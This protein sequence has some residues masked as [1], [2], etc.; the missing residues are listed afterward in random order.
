MICLKENRFKTKKELAEH[1]SIDVS[2][3]N[4]WL[5]LY[6]ESGIKQ[7]CQATRRNKPSKLISSEIH[8]W[9]EQLLYNESNHVGGYKHLQKLIA[10]KFGKT[11]PYYG[12]YFYIR[13][14]FK[15]KFKTP[16]KS[17]GKKDQQ[18]VDAFLK[19]AEHL[20]RH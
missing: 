9:L 12:L 15:A 6:R 19:T 18:A 3:L 13:K 8:K 14:K 5:K 11:I 10:E 17:H 16:R 4:R 1:L 20:E 2:T 7:M